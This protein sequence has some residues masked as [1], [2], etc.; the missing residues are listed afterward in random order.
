MVAAFEEVCL[1]LKALPPRN[2]I[3]QNGVD[4]ALELVA[5]DPEMALAKA[6]K[7]LE[8]IIEDLYSRCLQQPVGNR[9]FR[10]QVNALQQKKHL[11]PSL[12]AKANYV[13]DY[14]NFGAHPTEEEFSDRDALKILDSL[15]DIIEWYLKG[16]EPSPPPPVPEPTTIVPAVPKGLQTLDQGTGPSPPP[17]GHDPTTIVPIVPKGLQAFDQHDAEFFLQR[18]LV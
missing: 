18:V 2:R 12:G 3:T 8:S 16:A 11:P 4:K 15:L 10:N 17:P 13:R 7:V 5:I 14:G 6:R 9:D 1:R